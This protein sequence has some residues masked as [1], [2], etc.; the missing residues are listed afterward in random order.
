M[1]FDLMTRRKIT[2]KFAQSYQK[3]PSRKAKSLILDEFTH[4]TGY[5]RSYASWLLRNTGRRVRLS[6]GVILVGDSRPRGHR[7]PTY[8]PQVLGPLLQD[9]QIVPEADPS[10]PCQVDLPE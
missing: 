3:A 2:Q 1:E 10:I 6:S 5:N 9:V 7:R 4:L 8:G